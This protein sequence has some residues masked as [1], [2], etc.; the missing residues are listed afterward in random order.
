MLPQHAAHG[1]VFSEQQLVSCDKGILTNHG[2][3]GGLM[4]YAFEWV[5]DNNGICSE[6]SY[7][8]VSDDGS[9]PACKTTCS[10][11]AKSD[12]STYYDVKKNDDSA[13]ASAIALQPVSVAIQA[14][15]PAFQFYKSGVMT[16]DCG[17]NLDHGVLAV[18]YGTDNGLDYFNVKNSWGVTW[19]EQGYIR[20]ERVPTD[21]NGAGKCGIYA[22]PPSYPTTSA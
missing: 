14:N 17:A 2:C 10:N 4:D 12:V 16:G 18:G 6:A 21:N 1:L 19:G 20:I 3:N 8:Y 7:P 22:G 11:V 9:E 5:E 13:L 15:Q